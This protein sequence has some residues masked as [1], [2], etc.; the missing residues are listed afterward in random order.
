[1]KRALILI[2]GGLLCAAA[3]P[4]FAADSG[5]YRAPHN[6]LGQPDLGGTW[7]NASL[8]PQARSPL[9]G[10]RAVQSADEVKALEGAASDKATAGDAKSDLS[11]PIAESDNVGAYN[12]GWI[13]GGSRVMRVH[14]EARTSLLTTPDGQPPVR[15]GQSPRVLPADSGSV[16]AGKRAVKAAAAVDQL[17]AQGNT[18]GPAWRPVRQPGSPCAGRTLHPVLRTQRRPADVLQ[19][20]VQQQLSVRAE[21]RRRGHRH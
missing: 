6:S 19:R 21:P 2:A 13:D 15:K 18:T 8:T 17:A 10:M 4:A 16:E 5:A 1:M 20:M 12:Q 7:T 3:I 11:K 14:G 9:Y